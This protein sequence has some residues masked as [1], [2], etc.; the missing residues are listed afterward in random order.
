M[1]KLRIILPMLLG[2]AA[3]PSIAG[4]AAFN[5]DDSQQVVVFNGRFE[6]GVEC[7]VV[8]RC[9]NGDTYIAS[10]PAGYA[11]GDEVR[12]VGRLNYDIISFCQQG[13]FLGIISIR[14]S[15]CQ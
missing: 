14:A 11:I 12:I 7:N 6:Q 15:A 3:A 8:R 9:D 1:K 2:L 13:P 10:P 4:H 5:A